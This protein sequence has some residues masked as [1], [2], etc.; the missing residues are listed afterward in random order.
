MKSL[1]W[2]QKSTGK[3]FLK[4]NIR[5]HGMPKEIITQ[6]FIDELFESIE[7]VCM[8]M[9]LISTESMTTT[10]V[11]HI[12]LMAMQVGRILVGHKSLPMDDFIVGIMKKHGYYTG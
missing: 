1:N 2:L 12:E 11:S 7:G 6:A 4:K 9:S 3:M 8:G 5:Q 10:M